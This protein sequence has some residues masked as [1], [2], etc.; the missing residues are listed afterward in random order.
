MVAPNEDMIRFTQLSCQDRPRTEAI[1]NAPLA[2]TRKVASA[3]R[4]GVGLTRLAGG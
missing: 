2:N 3:L 1:R 4:K